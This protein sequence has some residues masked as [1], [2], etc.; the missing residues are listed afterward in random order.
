MSGNGNKNE[1]SEQ[2]WFELKAKLYLKSFSGVCLKLEPH[3]K[4]RQIGGKEC[5]SVLFRAL[6]DKNGH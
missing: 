3:L 2:E 1:L 6:K 4:E 5:I